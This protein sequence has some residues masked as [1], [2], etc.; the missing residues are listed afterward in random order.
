MSSLGRTIAILGAVLLAVG[1]IMML[2][3]RLGLTSLPG[4]LSF[5]KGRVAVYI[6]LGTSLLL[7]L[8]LTVLLNLF[9]RR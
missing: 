3:G 6:P 9:F 2:L 7:S 8:V 5:R 1:L 4:D